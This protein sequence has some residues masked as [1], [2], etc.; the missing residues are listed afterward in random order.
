MAPN[1]N[2]SNA[3]NLEP[4]LDWE[5][6]YNVQIDGC[7]LDAIKVLTAWVLDQSSS[8]N[9]LPFGVIAA[10]DGVS[11][12]PRRVRTMRNACLSRANK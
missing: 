1:W 3:L 11:S 7:A 10:C 6:T 8:E 12:I 2:P 4:S 9:P 5:T